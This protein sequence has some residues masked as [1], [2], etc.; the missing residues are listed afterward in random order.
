MVG[1][2]FLILMNKVLACFGK[3][4]SN[5]KLLTTGSYPQNFIPKYLQM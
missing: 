2:A 3:T 4:V 1:K 5:I